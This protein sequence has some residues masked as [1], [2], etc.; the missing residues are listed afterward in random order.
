MVS[1]FGIKSCLYK[2]I[3]KCNICKNLKFNNY[4]YYIKKVDVTYFNLEHDVWCYPVDKNLKFHYS[5]S[6]LYDNAIVKAVRLITLISN[7]LD[8]GKN[9]KLVLKE[10]GNNSYLTGI[11]SNKKLS[12]KYYKN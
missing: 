4:C 6:D 2:L 8:N 9:I 3:D 11:D 7:T 12:M 1:R 5:L 10:I